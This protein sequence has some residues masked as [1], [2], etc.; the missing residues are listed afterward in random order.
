MSEFCLRVPVP[1]TLSRHYTNIRR[2]RRELGRGDF[3][4]ADLVA[5]SFKTV[6]PEASYARARRRCREGGATTAKT[7]ADL[8]RA[9]P[10]ACDQDADDGVFP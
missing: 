3:V 9:P 5:A 4:A 2:W 10:R 8:E 6:K 7:P 1:W